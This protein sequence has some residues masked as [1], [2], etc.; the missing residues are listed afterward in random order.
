MKVLISYW[1]ED[2]GFEQVEIDSPFGL[3]KSL[4][5]LR[6]IVRLTSEALNLPKHISMLVE[7]M[8]EV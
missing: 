8:E 6:E 7:N 2:L 1:S 4:F 5:Q 3:P